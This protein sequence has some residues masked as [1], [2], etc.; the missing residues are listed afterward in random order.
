MAEIVV[1]IT[2]AD[3][4]VLAF[5]T[6]SNVT[7]SHL[8]DNIESSNGGT[9]G[10]PRAELMMCFNGVVLDPNEH[11]DMSLA[12][13][14]I[15][16]QASIWLV[17]RFPRLCHARCVG[18]MDIEYL[19][20]RE[21]LRIAV[22]IPFR[23]N[24]DILEAKLKLGMVLMVDEGRLDLW[25]Q[26]PNGASILLEDVETFGHYGINDGDT[27]IVFVREENEGQ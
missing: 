22:Y 8:A 23:S 27:L 13:A 11:G 4:Q 9:G 20:E 12:D 17:S 14:G 7:L 5:G 19:G 6:E 25:R 21:K 16:S 2:K 26:I 24:T 10:I 3:G 15:T 1:I 18:L